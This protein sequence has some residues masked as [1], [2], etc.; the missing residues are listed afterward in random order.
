MRPRCAKTEK[1]AAT[2]WL[3]KERFHIHVGGAKQCT[4]IGSIQSHEFGHTLQSIIW[5][6]QNLS[7]SL[8]LSLRN[9][10]VMVLNCSNFEGGRTK[11]FQFIFCSVLTALHSAKCCFRCLNSE[12]RF[13]LRVESKSFLLN[14]LQFKIEK[15]FSRYFL[16]YLLCCDCSSLPKWDWN[17][18]DQIKIAKCL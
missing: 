9:V 8:S 6:I 14:W 12:E 15:R 5:R 10:F 13:R 1:F 4:Q 3:Q 7:L 11:C 16:P 18:C 2:Y 17:Q